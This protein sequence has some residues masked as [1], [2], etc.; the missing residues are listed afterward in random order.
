MAHEYTAWPFLYS[1]LL[2]A[3]DELIA[4]SR[5][6]EPWRL[7]VRLSHADNFCLVVENLTLYLSNV[8][9]V[10]HLRLETPFALPLRFLEAPSSLLTAFLKHNSHNRGGG[11]LRRRDGTVR[12][13]SF[14]VCSS[15]DAMALRERVAAI[16]TLCV[17]VQVDVLT[18]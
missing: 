11:T 2:R 12:S 1:F 14:G 8:A 3:P 17:A 13:L 16:G 6:I 10:P 7:T 18:F 4:M 9:Y 5:P 15:H